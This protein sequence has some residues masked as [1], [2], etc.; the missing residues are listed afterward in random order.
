M[1]RKLTQQAFIDKSAAKYGDKFDY[2]CVEYTLSS[3]PVTIRC[4]AHDKIFTIVAG[5]H[6][7][8][9]SSGGCTM[10]KKEL[11]TS[12]TEEFINKSNI[13]HSNKFSYEK[14]VYVHAKEQVTI[15][16]ALHGDFE[17]LPNDHLNGCGCRTCRTENIGWSDTKWIDQGLKSKEFDGYKLY[18]IKLWDGEEFFYKI[19]KTFIGTKSRFSGISKFYS[20]KVCSTIEADGDTICKLERKYQRIN[21]EF[22]YLPKVQFCGH[23][24]CFTQVTLEGVTYE[25]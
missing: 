18:V 5:E 17:Q 25:N 7:R 4:I 24:E 15:T 14:T 22:K 16:C 11:V 2:S 23:T 1:A 3:A 19:G 13:V 6:T 8:K 20:Y 21:R 10:C 9:R 12:T